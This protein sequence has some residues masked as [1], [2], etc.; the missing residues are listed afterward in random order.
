MNSEKTKELLYK[1]VVKMPCSGVIMA[2]VLSDINLQ[3]ILKK[4]GAGK[5]IVV[6]YGEPGNG[7][8][9][10]VRN[11]LGEN[12]EIKFVAGLNAVKKIVKTMTDE[13]VSAAKCAERKVLFLDNFPEPLSVNKLE[14]CRGVL[15]Y[16]I[17]IVS[18]DEKAPMVVMTGELNIISEVE[19]ATSLMERALVLRMPKIDSDQELYEIREYFSI[20]QCEYVHQWDEYNKWALKNP[21]DEKEVLEMLTGFR[22]K[23][24]SAYENRQIGLVFCY[25]YAIYRFSRFLECAYGEGVRT[26][27]IERNVKE[28]F[29][30]RKADRTIQCSY[31]IEVWKEFLKDGGLQKVYMPSSSTCK[32]LIG[33]KCDCNEPYRCYFCE[34][35]EACEKYNPMELRLQ[36]DA[37]AAILIENGEKIPYFPKHQVCNG[38]LLVIRNEALHVMLN[39]YL[40]T[41]SRK[42]EISVIRI[43]SKRLNKALF[44]HNMC[45][46]EYVGTGHNTYTFKMKDVDNKDVRVLFIKLSDEDYLNLKAIAKRQT[47]Q[48]IYDSKSVMDMNK[49]LEYFG[50]NV[51]NLVGE[52]GAPSRVLD[53]ID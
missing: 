49:C 42:K 9:S 52:I 37:E 46:F 24:M 48:G 11:L 20:N 26:A 14:R 6:I 21:I 10:S 3:N 40:E 25:F 43:T 7:K 8:T 1:A 19:K 34:E 32:R 30:W 13:E 38:P 17:D 50:Q 4:Y 12:N 41:Y 18:E 36:S 22:K 5:P 33:S 16:V 28:L 2:R 44:N 53:A 51:Q 39:T 47:M 27:D 35:E 31:E 15:D 23:Y 45:L 29:D